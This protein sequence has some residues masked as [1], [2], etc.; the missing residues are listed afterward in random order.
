MWFTFPG[1]RWTHIG[2]SMLIGSLVGGV[3]MKEA[4][5]QRHPLPNRTLS[6]SVIESGLGSATEF[7]PWQTVPAVNQLDLISQTSWEYQALWSIAD[8]YGLVLDESV[9]SGTQ[10]PLTRYEFVATLQSAIAQIEQQLSSEEIYISRR[11]YVTLERLVEQF[12]D[13]IALLSPRL[14]DQEARVAGL[15]AARFSP[16]ARLR[17]EAVIALTDQFGGDRSVETTLQ[18]RSRL[19]IEASFNGRDRFQTRLV[20]GGTPLLIQGEGDEDE[21]SNETGEG[22]L[23]SSLGGNTDEQIELD[24]LVYE[25][26]LGNR[27]SSYVSATGG[28]HHHYVSTTANP[29]FDDGTGGNGSISAFS[30][31]SPIYSIGGGAGIGFDAILDANDRVALSVGYL[32]DNAADSDQE[33]GVFNGDYALLGQVSVYPTDQLQVGATYVRG[34]HSR[35]EAIFDFDGD[36]SL[37]IGSGFAN[38]THTRLNTSATT[39][40][41]GLQTSYR[42]SP[43]I[44]LNAFAGYTDIQ[45]QDVGSGDIWYYGLG[46]AFPDLLLPNSLAGILVGVEPYLGGVEGTSSIDIPNATSLHIEAF[47][48]LQLTDSISLT[49]GLIWITAPNQGDRPGLVVGTFRTTFRF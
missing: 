20:A 6:P 46:L 10:Q 19:T 28:M 3:P 9:P 2:I 22:T 25:F 18:H 8:T 5:A 11:D 43:S 31:F 14:T 4:I 38:Q 12:D 45:F 32:A 29:Y 33:S 13:S 30:Q 7:S 16:F 49:P 42:I 34:F 48:K 17:G 21:P 37:F 24:W 39:D 27:V 1:F 26:P 41:L 15:E 40:S 44:T 47:Y 23:V 35:G 36:E